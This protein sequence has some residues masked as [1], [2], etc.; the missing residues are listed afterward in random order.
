MFGLDSRGHGEHGGADP[1]QSGNNDVVSNRGEACYE[2]RP[3]GRRVGVPGDGAG[4]LYDIVADLWELRDL[5][6]TVGYR[7]IGHQ[8]RKRLIGMTG[9]D[10][11]PPVR[12]E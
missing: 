12:P 7:R 4:E 11:M 6:G 8:L 9:V 2:F 5:A 1:G 3:V 10:P